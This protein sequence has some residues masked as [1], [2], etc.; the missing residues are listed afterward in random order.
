MIKLKKALIVMLTTVMLCGNTV[1]VYASETESAQTPESSET[2]ES[3]DS[4]GGN[5]DDKNT[6]WIMACNQMATHCRMPTR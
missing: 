6:G 1:M 3:P 5:N 2:P 4:Q